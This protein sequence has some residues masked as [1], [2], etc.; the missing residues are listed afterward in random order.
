MR[1]LVEDVSDREGL[2]RALV[3]VVRAVYHA[4]NKA[5]PPSA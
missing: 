1:R 4:A 3:S 5:M 2:H